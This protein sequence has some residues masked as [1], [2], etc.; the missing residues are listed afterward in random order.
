MGI[1]HVP[2]GLA[3]RTRIGLYA[4]PVQADGAIAEYREVKNVPV[5]GVFD[6]YSVSKTSAVESVSGMD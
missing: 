2:A 3:F 6:D 5:F 1:Q 4:H